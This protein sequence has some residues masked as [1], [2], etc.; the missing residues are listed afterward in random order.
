[1]KRNETKRDENDGRVNERVYDKVIYLTT[2]KMRITITTTAT[3]GS[4][5]N[6]KLVLKYVQK[7]C[8]H[9]LISSVI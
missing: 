2:T 1:M 8:A 7:C 9:F 3:A 6:E 5:A 4:T